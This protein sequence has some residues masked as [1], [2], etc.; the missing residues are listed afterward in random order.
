MNESANQFRVYFD[1]GVNW[2]VNSIKSCSLKKLE[3]IFGC[4][5]LPRKSNASTNEPLHCTNLIIW[6]VRLPSPEPYHRPDSVLRIS[7]LAFS[8]LGHSAVRAC[9]RQF[10]PPQGYGIHV[11]LIA[12]FQA[13]L[14]RTRCEA[15]RFRVDHKS[16]L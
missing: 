2:S 4:N 12:D 14:L 13:H 11:P 5:P 10:C 15:N 6:W 8:I 9:G 3:A 16:Q 7:F 1:R